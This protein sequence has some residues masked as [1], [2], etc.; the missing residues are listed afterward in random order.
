M[1]DFLQVS[2]L[3]LLSIDFASAIDCSIHP[4]EVK[5][6]KRPGNNGYVI[7]ISAATTKSD[8]GT[9]G[10]IPDEL[11]KS[12]L[13]SYSFIFWGCKIWTEI[14]IHLLK[15]MKYRVSLDFLTFLQAFFQTLKTSFELISFKQ[16]FYFFQFQY[17]AGEQN[18]LCRPSEDS[19]YL[20]L[21]KM[22]SQLGNSKSW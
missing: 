21:L 15:D 12:N 18:I 13:D 22:E 17:E 5:D 2:F 19:S 14:S 20:Q 3:L 16:L 8:N 4:Y 10:F 11:Y 6:G 7:E 9:T 1:L